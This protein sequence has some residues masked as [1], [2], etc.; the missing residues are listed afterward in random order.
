MANEKSGRSYDDACGT[1][2]ALDL[3][4]ERW[5]ML[6]MR[7]LLL[8]PRRF[9]DL[10]SGLPGISANVLTQRLEG[11]EASG[12]VV[13]RKLPPPAS[14]QVYELTEWGK[15]A[16][17]FILGLGKWAARSPLHDVS[18]PLS[19]VGMMLSFRAMFMP[20]R[21]RGAYFTVGFRLGEDAYWAQVKD[22]ELAEGRGEAAR[23]DLVL[24]G[25]PGEIAG[26]VHGF[27]DPATFEKTGTLKV[28]GD[29][30]ALARFT[31]MFELPPKVGAADAVRQAAAGVSN[32]P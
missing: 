10:R 16:E 31:T 1:A 23:A 14:V 9:G 26:V 32:P 8:G 22:G 11:L 5:A 18:A 6:V 2:H 29:R 21:A 17:P 3:I 15:E 7:E 30:A 27:A 20:E 24:T 25:I 28:E 19:A 13:R 12:V 4:G